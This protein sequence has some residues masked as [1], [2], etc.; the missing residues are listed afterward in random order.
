MQIVTNSRKAAI[1]G[2]GILVGCFMS[3]C[4]LLV[5]I[6][7]LWRGYREHVIDSRW[8][9]TPANVKTCALDV[10]RP[11]ARHGVGAAFSLRCRLSYEFQA[12]PYQFTLHTTSN[13][14]AGVRNE[15]EEWV[16]THGPGSKLDVLVNPANP[17][18]IAVLNVLP[19]EQF[20]TAR[21]AWITALIFLTG[22]AVFI[23]VG[24]AMRAVPG[25]VVRPSSE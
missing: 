18:E 9:E 11:S 4:G 13:R 10:H 22:A 3:F 2:I 7:A 15:I 23:L 14:I 25:Q 24:R 1:G 20:N 19:V 6:T 17:N 8:V 12:R 16:A 5:L 21:E